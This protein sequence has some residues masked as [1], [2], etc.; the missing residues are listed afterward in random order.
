MKVK[1]VR[2]PFDA[3][4]QRYVDFLTADGA[5]DVELDIDPSTH[6]APDEQIEVFR[7]VQEGL[8]NVRKHARAT[9]ARVVIA[10]R[11]G[12]RFVRIRDDGDGFDGE[13]RAAGQ[14]LKNIAPVQRASTASSR[15]ARG[16]A[17]ARRSRSRCGRSAHCCQSPTS[18]RRD[19]RTRGPVSVAPQQIDDQRRRRDRNPPLI[20]APR[21]RAG[22]RLRGESLR[23]R[24]LLRN[25]VG[26]EAYLSVVSLSSR[27]LPTQTSRRGRGN[28]ERHGSDNHCARGCR[29]R[30]R[31]RGYRHEEQE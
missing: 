12:R 25:G 21:H 10:Q 29:V 11:D 5:L 23:N 30:E 15:S 27:P 18:A 9:R 1:V 26:D 24:H 22:E 2:A 19:R 20:R 8:A 14:G 13:E 7:I 28:H 6:L 31:D 17:A 16:R 4:L 3:A